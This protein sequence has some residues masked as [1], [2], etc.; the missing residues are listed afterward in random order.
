MGVLMPETEDGTQGLPQKPPPVSLRW[1]A[2]LHAGATRAL[3]GGCGALQ[4]GRTLAHPEG[5]DAWVSDPFP[6]RRLVVR[7]FRA[8]LP[9]HGLILLLT[10][11][12]HPHEGA[13]QRI[14]AG[15]Q[16]VNDTQQDKSCHRDRQCCPEFRCCE[17]G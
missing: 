4:A 2:A 16:M 8:N 13:H 7:L 15:L 11:P 9:R 5:C 3:P 14:C 10:P 12:S 1:G 17:I 6:L